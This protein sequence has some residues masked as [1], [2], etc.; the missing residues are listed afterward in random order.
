MKLLTIL[1]GK[2]RSIAII[3][4]ALVGWAWQYHIVSEQ[5]L[6]LG[7]V[8]VDLL[9]AGAIAHAVMKARAK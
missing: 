3:L 7:N 8:A 1:D 2:K 4:S 6:S 9:G 5:W